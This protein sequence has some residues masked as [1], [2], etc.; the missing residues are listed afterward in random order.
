MRRCK[1]AKMQ[2]R[3]LKNSGDPKMRSCYDAEGVKTVLKTQRCDDA[4][5]VK[6]LCR[7][8]DAKMRRCGE[9]S[10]NLETPRSE[11][12]EMQ[13]CKGHFREL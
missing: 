1:D 10:K 4:E 8:E 3:G 2:M 6:K 5:G 12:A 11:D 13:S 9:A 7:P